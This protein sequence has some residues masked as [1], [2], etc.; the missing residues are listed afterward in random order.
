MNVTAVR[1]SDW[2]K[3]D[4][5]PI[6]KVSNVTFEDG[7]EVAGYDLPP[8]IEEGKPLP[9]GW[10]VATSAK[11]KPYIKVPKPRGGGGGFGGGAAAYRNTK[12]GQQFEAY[13]RLVNTAIMQAEGNLSMA[14]VILAWGEE[15]LFKGSPVHSGPPVA[16]NQPTSSTAAV[17]VRGAT[18]TGQGSLG[19]A[20]PCP[21]IADHAFV[22]GVCKKCGAPRP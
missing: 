13:A 16:H 11:G 8:G 20:G 15:Q 2:D 10:E 1:V 14:A 18:G 17:G 22:K 7:K 21:T 6:V 12:E 5:S 4:G 19:E 3:K 9:Q